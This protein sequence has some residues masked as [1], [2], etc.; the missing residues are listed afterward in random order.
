MI[1]EN[2]KTLIAKQ[3]KIYERLHNVEKAC[4]QATLM[5]QNQSIRECKVL[6]AKVLRSVGRLTGELQDALQIEIAAALPLVSIDAAIDVE[7]KLERQEYFESMK[8]YLVQIKGSI[9]TVDE[10]FRR[11]ITDDLAFLFNLDGRKENRGLTQLKLFNQVL[12]EVFATEGRNKFE[13]ALRKSIELSHN[14]YH[15]KKFLLSKK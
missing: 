6:V 9:G 5:E 13:K 2:Q 1:F 11:V 8:D 4:D 3:Q 7:E 15:Q 12:Y 10:V 14:R